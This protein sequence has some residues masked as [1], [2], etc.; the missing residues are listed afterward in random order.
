MTG[1]DIAATVILVAAPDTDTLRVY[2]V[3]V[4]R[5][6]LGQLVGDQHGR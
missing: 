1:I 5:R 3:A 4:V 6:F 2:P